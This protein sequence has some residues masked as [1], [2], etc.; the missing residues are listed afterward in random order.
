MCLGCVI[1]GKAS[2]LNI[3][4]E[5]ESQRFQQE[6]QNQFQA[7]RNEQEKYQAQLAEVMQGLHEKINVME[8]SSKE[9]IVPTTSVPLGMATRVNENGKVVYKLSKAPDLPNFSGIELV[10]REEGSFKQ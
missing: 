10:P 9:M 7:M 3:Y 8:K 1:S 6:V 2:L 4:G 5:R